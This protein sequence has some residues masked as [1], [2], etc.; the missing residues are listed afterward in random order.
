MAAELTLLLH[1]PYWVSA[2]W[3]GAGEAAVMAT[4]GAALFVLVKRYGDSFGLR[5]PAA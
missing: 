3:V 2:A 5:R 4:G 1:L